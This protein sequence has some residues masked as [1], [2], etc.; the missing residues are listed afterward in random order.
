M[1]LN[2]INDIENIST[3]YYLAV[4]SQKHKLYEKMWNILDT[5]Y[6]IDFVLCLV[7]NFEHILQLNLVKL[8]QVNDT[9]CVGCRYIRRWLH[10]AVLPSQFFLTDW[11]HKHRKNT[12]EITTVCWN[13][14]LSIFQTYVLINNLVP[15]MGTRLVS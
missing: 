8:E 13:V 4:Q 14:L 2:D 9:G 6:V 7:V 5:V 15:A 11:R 10:D 12:I 1:K 3:S